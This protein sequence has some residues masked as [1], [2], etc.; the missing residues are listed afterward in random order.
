MSAEIIAAV[1]EMVKRGMIVADQ[2]PEILGFFLDFQQ[3]LRTSDGYKLLEPL[4]QVIP[5]Q[6]LK[7]GTL[8]YEDGLVLAWAYAA[9][10]MKRAGS[11][12]K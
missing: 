10:N 7:F 9:S 3:K 8:S 5:P 12:I 2:K 6:M 4:R 1:D 11:S